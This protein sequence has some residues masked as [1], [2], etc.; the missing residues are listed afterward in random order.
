MDERKTW[1]DAQQHCRDWGG[2][3]MEVRTQHQ[4]DESVKISQ[5]LYEQTTLYMH[6]G[7]SDAALEGEWRWA[8][9]G[10]LIDMTRF[11]TSG[12]PDSDGDYLIVGPPGFYD[13]S[14]STRSFAC[15]KSIY[16][17]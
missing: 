17:I 16:W 7:G 4:F 9:N 1:D 6:L 3:I 2:F 14:T 8:S 13:A 15:V 10:E 5:V 11:W 12:E